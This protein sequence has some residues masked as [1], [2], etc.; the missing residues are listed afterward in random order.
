MGFPPFFNPAR[1]AASLP[2]SRSWRANTI[3]PVGVCSAPVT[4]T[5]PVPQAPEGAGFVAIALL[6]HR[7]DDIA[8]WLIEELFVDDAARTAFRALAETEGD[9]HAALARVEGEAVEIIER[10]AVYDGDADPQVEARVLIAAAVRREL[11]RSR[12]GE[13]LERIQDDRRVRI[14]LEDL[15]KPDRGP[16]AA[17]EVLQWLAARA[18]EVA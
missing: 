17:V 6:V 15:A 9:V 16:A 4:V 1:S 18:A 14:A 2:R 10:A 5:A 3:R 8:P 11:A 7:W 13:D 12:P